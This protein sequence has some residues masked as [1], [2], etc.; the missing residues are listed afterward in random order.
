MLESPDH[1]HLPSA[2]ILFDLFSTGVWLPGNGGPQLPGNILLD[3]S[4]CTLSSSLGPW[5]LH[6]SG[7]TMAL[8]LCHRMSRQVA[9]PPLP[10]KEPSNKVP[11]DLLRW[12]GY[13][14][15]VSESIT[16]FP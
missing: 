14:G 9:G 4:P 2:E 11:A 12:V 15:R 3:T 6:R 10:E 8:L 7:Q 13:F 16:S 5:W 1:L